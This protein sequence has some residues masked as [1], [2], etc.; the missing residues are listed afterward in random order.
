MP[1]NRALITP[2]V[3]FTPDFR[4][5]IEFRVNSAPGAI[6]TRKS[7]VNSTQSGVNST[8]KAITP[9]ALLTWDLCLVI[10]LSNKIL[11]QFLRS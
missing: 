6:I 7:G 11:E 9:R 2:G 4:V 3:L 1:G 5:L 8:R 10:L